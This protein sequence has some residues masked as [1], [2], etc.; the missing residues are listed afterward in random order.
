MAFQLTLGNHRPLGADGSVVEPTLENVS[1]PSRTDRI[2]LRGWLFKSPLPSGRSEIVVHGFQQNRVNADFGGVALSKD[3]LAHGYD[4]LL[5]DFAPVATATAAVSPLANS[6][7]AICSALM[8]SCGR[9][10][11]LP[12]RLA[13]I[14]DREGAATVIG[15]ARNLARV[16]V[17][18]ADSL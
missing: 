1:F 2:T 4:V 10:H 11:Y 13:V 14:G 16:G 17:L 15:A 3:L 6:N 12:P 18:M 9:A 5:I 8:T 7:P